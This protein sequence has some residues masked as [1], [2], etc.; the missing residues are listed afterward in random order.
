MCDG[1]SNLAKS[2]GENLLGCLVADRLLPLSA[3]AVPAVL[4]LC[5]APDVARG[6]AAIRAR[7]VDRSL[8]FQFSTA[9]LQ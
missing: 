9:P 3:L 7:E 4:E 1:R 6:K 8:P 2:A 5:D